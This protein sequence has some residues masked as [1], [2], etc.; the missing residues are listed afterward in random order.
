MKCECVKP[1]GTYH[2]GIGPQYT[3]CTNKAEY[4]VT[5]WQGITFRACTEHFDQL[6]PDHK[7]FK[8]YKYIGT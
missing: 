8:S 1:T 4:R 7:G 5:T 6:Y 2:S 3:K